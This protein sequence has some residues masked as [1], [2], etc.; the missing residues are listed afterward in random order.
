[1]ELIL[2]IDVGADNIRSVLFSMNGNIIDETKLPTEPR[3]TGKNIISKINYLIKRFKTK[4]LKCIGIGVP[5]PI[6]RKSGIIYPV[7]IPG[8]YG[9][10]IMDALNSFNIPI[11]IENHANCFVLAEQKFGAA[12]N[13]NHVLGVTMGCSLSGGLILNGDLYRG[14]DG[15]AGEIGHM[16][17]DKEGYLC[18]CKNKGCFEMYV[19]G[20][21]IEFRTHRHIQARDIPT[22]MPDD[23]D[24]VE[25]IESSRKGDKLAKK[26]MDDTGKYLG[27]GISSLIN[28]FNPEIIVLGGAVAKAFPA[29]KKSM[30][31][32]IK[33][34]SLKPANNVK[35]V[36]FKLEHPGAFGAAFSALKTY[37]PDESLK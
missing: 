32:E 13:H 26:I 21:A 22:R 20:E 29:F 4:H 18:N 27:I 11:N 7:N 35:I 6:D 31:N 30:M 24:V 10:K 3:S 33:S 28:I 14:R 23:V 37:F 8:L 16:T 12:K 25:I 17:I 34:R 2:G 19:S 5:G 1:M 9:F 15:A 36:R